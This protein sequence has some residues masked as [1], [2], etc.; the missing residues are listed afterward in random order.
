[1]RPFVLGAKVSPRGCSRPLQR[2][3]TD[4]AADDPFARVQLKLRE[5]YGFEIGESTIQ[6]ITLGHA[7]AIFESG[8]P[9]P[10][11]PRVPGQHKQIVAQIDGGMVPVVTPDADRKDKRKGKTLSWREAK[12]SLAH[13]KGSRTPVY[14]GGIEG[15]VEEAG[16]R[17]FACAVRA[18]FGADSHV[19]A[20]GDGA[21]PASAG[22]G[23]GSWA[24]SKNASA[25]KAA[26]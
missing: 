23:C 6:R 19:H 10:E 2:A 26:I 15:G 8:H 14:G 22:A 12:I 24:R 11:F 17:L 16:R 5:H 21:P 4:F 18:G 13:A 20:V 3:I 7:Q 9:S 1:V 25:N